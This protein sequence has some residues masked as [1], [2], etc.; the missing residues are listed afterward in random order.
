MNRGMKRIS[1]VL[2]GILCSVT[3][4]PQRVSHVFKGESLAKVLR[5]LDHESADYRINFIFDEL[6]DFVVTTSF[7]NKNIPNAIRDVVG[8]Y[9][10]RIVMDEKHRN[11]F[12]ECMQKKSNK[13]IGR[14]IDQHANAVVYANVAL[15]NVHD[16]TLITG[17][18]S[19]ESGDFVIPTNRTKVLMRGS[20]VGYRNSENA[21]ANDPTQN[22]EDNGLSPFLSNRKRGYR[23]SC[24]RHQFESCGHSGRCV[25]HAPEHHRRRRLYRRFR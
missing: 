6:E 14:L 5:V 1:L 25:G 19:N 2:C 4:K 23:C 3:A 13:L 20:C 15:L 18:V 12:V 11:I 7:K 21:G 24:A 10:I 8:F 9:P 16:S 22:R 17:G